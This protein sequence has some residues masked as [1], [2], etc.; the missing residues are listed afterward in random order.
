L[1]TFPDFV[2]ELDFWRIPF[3]VFKPELAKD[4]APAENMNPGTRQKSGSGTKT[5]SVTPYKN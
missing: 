4:R 1:V 3:F 2:T 5:G